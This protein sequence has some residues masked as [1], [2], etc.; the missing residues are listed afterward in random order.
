[1]PSEPDYLRR[2]DLAVQRIMNTVEMPDWRAAD[3]VMF[4]RQNEGSL[5][6]KRREREF[7]PLT[8]GEVG[9]LEDIVRD[10]FKGFEG[11]SDSHSADREAH[12]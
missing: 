4:V 9:K 11:A 10:T 3:F 1:L 7:T 12:A 2:H 5:S 8:D 6:R